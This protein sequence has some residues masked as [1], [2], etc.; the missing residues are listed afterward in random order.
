[1]FSMDLA[2]AYR[3]LRNCP[4][5]LPLLCYKWKNEYFTDLAP[6]FGLRTSASFCNR[7]TSA[8]KHFMAHLHHS[9]LNYID[10]LAGVESSAIWCEKA[11]CTLIELLVELGVQESVEKRTTP[12]QI[13][14]WIGTIFNSLEFSMSIPQEKLID[15]ANVVNKS[16]QKESLNR[17]EM[18]SVIGKCLHIAQCSRPARLFVNT[19]LND[20]REMTGNRCVLSPQ[21]RQDLA[22]FRDLLPDYNGVHFIAPPPLPS[23]LQVIIGV[24]EGQCFA[25]AGHE[26]I[27]EQP[28][29]NCHPNNLFAVTAFLAVSVWAKQWAK[30]TVNLFVP[31]S[32][33]LDALQS[34]ATNDKLLQSI[35][36]QIWKTAT[37]YDINLWFHQ[38][39][40]LPE[41]YERA[42]KLKVPQKIWKSLN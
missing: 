33:A 3:Q 8:I 19:L 31:H 14:T 4:T 21:S 17:R 25:A 30:F 11:M 37:I 35:T 26:W 12:S 39:M 34:G 23:H 16:L 2:R 42:T 22:W 9:I 27:M 29:I 18:Q 7:T 38:A 5:S 13:M 28:Q 10:D 24:K 32:P 1:M 6:C 36:R 20:L 15:I 41:L 40:Y